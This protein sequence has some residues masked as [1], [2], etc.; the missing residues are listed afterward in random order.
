LVQDVDSEDF[1][2]PI[3][4]GRI[5]HS[6]VKHVVSRDKQIYLQN[7]MLDF[8]LPLDSALLLR[9]S[10]AFQKIVLIQS[11]AGMGVG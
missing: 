7:S 1:S 6:Q 3:R 4:N 8:Y 2:G 5:C 11:V 10:I 9:R